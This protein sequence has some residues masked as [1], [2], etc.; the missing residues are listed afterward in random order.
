MNISRNIHYTILIKINGR[1][2]E[3]NFR[4]RSDDLYDSDTSD[5]RGTRF[6]FKLNRTEGN[7]EITGL[8]VPAWILDNQQQIISAVQQEEEKLSN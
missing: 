3:F 4:K 8:N 2:R 7:W 1:L 5:E 6:Q